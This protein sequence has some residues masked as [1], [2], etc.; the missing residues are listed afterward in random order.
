MSHR[1]IRRLQ[2]RRAREVDLLGASNFDA[3]LRCALVFPNTYE[4]GMSNLGL[5]AVYRHFN[6]LPSV[7]CERA[8]L[9]DPH[10]F[11]EHRR[12]R[13]PLRTIETQTPLSE[14]DLVAFSISFER[15]YTNVL[16]ALELAG[17]PPLAAERNDFHPIV[18][19]GGP[20]MTFNP[21]PIADF[22]D[23]FAIGEGEP[24]CPE[25]GR[26]LLDSWSGHPRRGCR[27][28]RDGALEALA[29]IP[30]VYVPVQYQC[31]QGRHIVRRLLWNVT[32][33]AESVVLTPDTEFADTFLIEVERGCGRACRFCVS[34]HITR[35]PRFRRME[36]VLA[37][38]QRVRSHTRR[39]GLVGA[40][41][42]EQPQLAELI[43]TLGVDGFCVSVS[44]VR[45]DRMDSLLA[46][47]L[48]RACCRTVTL[49]PEAGTQRLRNVT[50]KGITEEQILQAVQHLEAAGVRQVK[51]Y[52]LYGIPTETDEDVLAIAELCRRIQAAAPRVRLQLSVN[53]FVPKPFTPWQWEPMCDLKTLERRRRLLLESLPSDLRPS[54]SVE[55]AKQAAIQALL[56]RGEHELGGVL[57]HLAHTGQS[58]SDWQAAVEQAGI[59]FQSRVFE[60][61]DPEDTLPWDF[62]DVGVSKDVL[63]AEREQ[64]LQGRTTPGCQMGRCSRCEVCELLEKESAWAGRQ[65]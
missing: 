38:I 3:A 15:D 28:Y 53:P 40:A 25:I 37:R 45:V 32:E 7:S 61:M 59:S 23:A 22:I 10:D 20:A 41:V 24:L 11:N 8:F 34:G 5:H 1:L 18:L 30:G 46:Q 56:A 54:A 62:I 6:I 26:V 64:S 58:W 48:A 52:F 12:T 33:A 17:I 49:A 55:T 31:G 9:P 65:P 50:N 35:P 47:A 14:F 39:V 29:E 63:L 2:Q 21:A 36:E 57:L 13:S 42:G 43:G 19:A 4:V 51:L 44:S 60:A 16:R 27:D